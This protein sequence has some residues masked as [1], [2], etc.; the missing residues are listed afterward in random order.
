LVK[1]LIIINYALCAGTR[2]EK[3][4]TGRGTGWQRE[5]RIERCLG[6][7]IGGV[8]TAIEGCHGCFD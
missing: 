7:A 8:A 4:R 2:K 3:Q 5:M 6:W 1:K